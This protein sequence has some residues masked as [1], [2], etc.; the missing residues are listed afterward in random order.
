MKDKKLKYGFDSSTIQQHKRSALTADRSLALQF[1]PTAEDIHSN[2]T[3]QSRNPQNEGLSIIDWSKDAYWSFYNKKKSGEIDIDSHIQA[4]AYQTQDGI[5]DA[6]YFK[7]NED[8]LVEQ[9][10]NTQDFQIKKQKY[11]QP[12]IISRRRPEF[13]RRT[14]RLS[15]Y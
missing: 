13:W 7:S 10:Q 4:L 15:Q 5:D 9:E 12:N 6:I 8:E 1:A 11:E 2:I 3:E 14:K